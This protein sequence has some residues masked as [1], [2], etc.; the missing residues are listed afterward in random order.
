MEKFSKFLEDYSEWK[1]KN[2]PGK[3]LDEYDM[4]FVRESYSKAVKAE[5]KA[6]KE[7]KDLSDVEGS[8]TNVLSAHKNEINKLK[9]KAEIVDYVTNLFDKEKI[10]TKASNRLLTTLAKAKS[11]KDAVF[12]MYNSILKGAGDGVIKESTEETVENKEEAPLKETEFQKALKAFAEFKESKGLGPVTRS[13]RVRI[14]EKTR[15]EKSRMVENK[16]TVKGVFDK[17]TESKKCVALAQKRLSEGDVMGAADATMAAGTAVTGAEA[18][19]NAMATPAAPV[20]QEVVDQISQVKTAVDALAAQAGIASPVDMGADP[21][22][23]VPAVTG[24]PADPAAAPAPAAPVT[25]SRIEASQNRIAEGKDEQAKPA[26]EIP[27]EKELVKGVA[28]G[29]SNEAKPADTWPTKPL[30]EVPVG[31]KLGNVEE[32]TETTAEPAK[33]QIKESEEFTPDADAEN[34]VE[35]STEANAEADKI[36]ESKEEA[37]AQMGLAEQRLEAELAKRNFKWGD[38]LKSGF[39]KR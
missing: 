37:P 21:N 4:A 27:S 29:A 20:P 39:N 2:H 5:E 3:E 30:N 23:G 24:A 31:K 6:L 28:T 32:S 8:M 34:K 19:A 36:E 25:E 22:A 38:F 35:E 26:I 7:A 13:E 14:F 12:A 1:A 9:T 17:L 15:S 33:D 11:D 16:I 10:N 18:D